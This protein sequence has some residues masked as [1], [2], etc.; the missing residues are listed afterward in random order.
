M[1]YHNH[2][3]IGRQSRCQLP[4][5]GIKVDPEVGPDGDVAVAGQ[6]VSS[7]KEGRSYSPDAGDLRG[8]VVEVGL[9]R[10]EQAAELWG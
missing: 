8:W 3:N 9:R 1:G 2:L 4:G 6:T 7:S 5:V 10:L